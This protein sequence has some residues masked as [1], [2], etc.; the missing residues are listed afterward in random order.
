MTMRSRP[1]HERAPGAGTRHI[2][3][4]RALLAGVLGLAAALLIAC[5]SSGKGLI[6]VANSG[7]LQSDFEAV[8]QAAE[9][10]SGNCSA[11]EAALLKTAE[12]FNALPASVDSGLHNTLRQ[13]IDN[14]RTRAL[15]LCTQPIVK[16]TTNPAPKTTTTATTPTTSTPTVTQP[17]SKPSQPAPES[18]STPSKGG[19]AEAPVETPPASG[20]PGSELG[21]S[22]S[23]GSPG[24]AGAPESGK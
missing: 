7:P 4:L 8:R 17:P 6:P 16:T 3:V 22:R 11:T 23:G 5:G 12:D 15:A 13:G 9:S 24:G 14:L 19:G 1:A 21:E 2:H 18:P 20:E 10:G